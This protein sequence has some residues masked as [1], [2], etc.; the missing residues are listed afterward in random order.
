MLPFK[1]NIP[2]ERFPLI[3]VAFIIINVLVYLLLELPNFGTGFQQASFFSNYGM[4]PCVVSGASCSLSGAPD[5]VVNAWSS[6]TFS[7]FP[8]LIT[9]MFLHGSLL[10]LGGNMLFLWIFGNNVED[11]MGRMRFI[12]FYLLCGLV[13]SAAQ[14]AIE[15]TSVIPNVGAS[16]AI[17]GVLGAYILLYPRARVTTL[18]FLFVFIT[19]IE[20]PA[21]VVLLLWFVLQLFSGTSSLVGG[22]GGGGVAYFAHVGGFIAGFALIKLFTKRRSPVYVPHQ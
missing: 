19:F 2:T 7:A 17:A 12:A 10:H 21:V 15:P 13:A 8:T 18:V 6:R 14:I 5:I 9:S 22:A 3:T 20:L 16:G 11:S 1:D 4:T